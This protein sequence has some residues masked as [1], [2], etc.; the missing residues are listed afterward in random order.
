MLIFKYDID[1]ACRF[2]GEVCS[3]RDSAAARRESDWPSSSLASATTLS[4]H[5][6]TRSQPPV[7]DRM[8]VSNSKSEAVLVGKKRGGFSGFFPFSQCLLLLYFRCMASLFCKQ[9]SGSTTGQYLLSSR[10]T[11]PYRVSHRCD[12]VDERLDKTAALGRTPH[13]VI[14]CGPE[15]PGISG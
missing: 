7:F 15:S 13:S 2:G 8:A 11:Q 6:V 14:C 9:E 1:W 10:T 3:V 4:R 12:R 5:A